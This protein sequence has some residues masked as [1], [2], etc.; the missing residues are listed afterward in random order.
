MNKQVDLANPKAHRGKS[1]KPVSDLTIAELHNESEI[2]LRFYNA[3]T[4]IEEK[5]T[6][7]EYKWLV[8]KFLPQER[9]RV[10]VE[11]YESISSSDPNFERKHLIAHG[12]FQEI[13]VLTSKLNDVIREKEDCGR[14]IQEISDQITKVTQRNKSDGRSS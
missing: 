6:T 8:D 12:Q 5:L 7:P 1:L 4:D 13:D 9:I 3:L 2:L 10:A 14:R 11:S